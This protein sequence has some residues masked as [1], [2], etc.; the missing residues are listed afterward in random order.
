MQPSTTESDDSSSTSTDQERGPSNLVPWIL[1]WLIAFSILAVLVYA[2]YSA[3]MQ[4]FRAD[5]PY[6][7]LRAGLAAGATR[8]G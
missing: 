3:Q 4:N 1:L 7:A 2:W 6:G 8:G 5:A